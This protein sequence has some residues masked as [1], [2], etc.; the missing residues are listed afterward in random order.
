MVTSC[1]VHRDPTTQAGTQTHDFIFTP[2]LDR[3]FL[4]CNPALLFSPV[5]GLVESLRD[6]LV[7][8]LHLCLPL[9]LLPAPFQSLCSIAVLQLAAKT[10]QQATTRGLKPLCIGVVNTGL[11]L[12]VTHRITALPSGVPASC[13]LHTNA[14]RSAFRCLPRAAFAA[15]RASSPTG[16]A[17]A[18]TSSMSAASAPTPAPLL[19]PCCLANAKARSLDLYAPGSA[20]SMPKGALSWGSTSQRLRKAGARATSSGTSP[21][22]RRWR[23][24]LVSTARGAGDSAP[25]VVAGVVDPSPEDQCALSRRR[26]A[27][28]VPQGGDAMPLGVGK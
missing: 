20:G 26:A 25:C 15:T 6:P 1:H 10:P 19:V 22:S 14:V 21:R 18:A 23:C 27:R 17:N 2:Q 24:A 8:R 3:K 5:G 4:A 28:E 11:F 16:C 9:L 13:T 12:R 7:L